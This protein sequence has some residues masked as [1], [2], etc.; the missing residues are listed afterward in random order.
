MV[1]IRCWKSHIYLLFNLKI[2]KPITAEIKEP[3]RIPILAELIYVGVFSK[4][5]LATKIAIVNPIPAK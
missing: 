3:M 4:A 1:S 5:K 2:A